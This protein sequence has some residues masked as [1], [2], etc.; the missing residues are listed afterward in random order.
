[1]QRQRD[2]RI[3]RPRAVDRRSILRGL[4][5]TGLAGG[6]LGATGGG[7]SARAGTTS[8]RTVR[9]SSFAAN[10]QDL[11]NEITIINTGSRTDRVAYR[12]AVD[13]RLTPGDEAG[14]DDEIDGNAVSGVIEGVGRDNYHF[15]GTITAFEIT[16]GAD[17][18]K[19]LLDGEVVEEPAE[20][21]QPREQEC[22]EIRPLGFRDQTVT[23]FYGYTPDLSAP[24]PRQSNT[25]TNLERA[26]VSR[27]FLFAGPDGLSLVIIH[28]G[29][30]GEPGG[31]ASFEVT[32]LPSD[33]E[34]VVLDDSHEGS[35]DVFEIEE[36]SASLHWAWGVGGRNDGAAFRGL[37]DEF[38]V[39]IDPAFGE[40]ARRDPLGPGRVTELQVLS[41]SA[42][43]PDVFRA[44]L[45]QPLVF[46]T[47]GC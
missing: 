43:D 3:R 4:L 21:P 14:D 16:A 12:L 17:V 5:T 10:R 15:S 19:V 8:V 18:A 22:V 6:A 35:D 28:G 34:W 9:G 42:T 41:G 37:G 36:T 33:G 30:E 39:R 7:A 11:P 44:P 13:G 25:P 45:D 23:E 38:R 2:D 27:L 20:P 31:A 47:G 46:A 32:G 1:M 40:A 24:N 26:G 29:G